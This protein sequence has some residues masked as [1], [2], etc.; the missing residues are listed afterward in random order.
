ME[1]E[2]LFS[3]VTMWCV[4]LWLVNVCVS[5]CVC[6]CVSAGVYGV[7]REK[8]YIWC[9]C[10]FFNGALCSKTSRIPLKWF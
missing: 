10:L 2:C 8:H 1:G 9:V 4:N 7:Y 5:V 6:Q 3:V